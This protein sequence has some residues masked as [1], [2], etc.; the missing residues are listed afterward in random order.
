MKKITITLICLLF[1][2]YITP[3]YAQEDSIGTSR[4]NP[5]SPLYFLKSVREVLEL[6]FAKTTNAKA[7]YQMEFATRRIRE[8]KSLVNSTHQDL[9]QPTLEKYWQHIKE[10]NGVLTL[11]DEYMVAKA[12]E[13]IPMHLNIL[14]TEYLQVTSEDAKRAISL[15]V[16]RLSEWEQEII[17]RLDLLKSTSVVGKFRESKLSGCNFLSKEASSSAL[18]EVEKYVYKER[19]IKC[20]QINP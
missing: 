6:K 15:T 3:A 10:L 14:Q 4:I 1:T 13:E 18:G 2:F 7:Y 17:T 8:V 11:T 20:L 19:A 16:N 12:S 5:A 9:I